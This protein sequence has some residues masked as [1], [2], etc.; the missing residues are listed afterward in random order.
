MTDVHFSRERLVNSLV[1]G[2]Y[3]QGH[4]T[5]R[6]DEDGV[7]RHCCLGVACDIYHEYTGDGF[8]NEDNEFV[9]T[10]GHKI[11]GADSA[12]REGGDFDTYPPV[13]VT[14][15]FGF[16]V[17]EVRS[18]VRMNDGDSSHAGRSFEFIAGWLS[19]LDD[20]EED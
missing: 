19:G 7:L 17:E 18:M 6:S 9:L 11:L 2:D 15:F 8:W 16:G 4:H 13:E 5:L 14:D 20:D 10:G 3:T 12:D 1:S